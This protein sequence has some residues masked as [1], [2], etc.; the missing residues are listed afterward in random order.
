MRPPHKAPAAGRTPPA[1]FLARRHTP[2]LMLARCNQGSKSS[3]KRDDL[4]PEG[5]Q[6]SQEVS[7]LWPMMKDQE[8][9]WFERQ[10]GVGLALVV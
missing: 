9:V 4:Q 5:E 3:A 7:P 6:K 2:H 8:L 1:F 10:F